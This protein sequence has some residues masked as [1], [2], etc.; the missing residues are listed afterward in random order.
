MGVTDMVSERGAEEEEEVVVVETGSDRGVRRHIRGNPSVN[1]MPSVRNKC[2]DN[3]DD[4]DD[5]RNRRAIS[6]HPTVRA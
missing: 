5:E 3:D 6:M 4:D 2:H 1:C